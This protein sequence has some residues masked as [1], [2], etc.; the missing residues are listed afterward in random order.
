MEVY[1]RLV[2][3]GSLH[4]WM[5]KDFNDRCD[6]TGSVMVLFQVK[7][8]DCIG[9]YTS[10][11]EKKVIHG[12]KNDDKAVLFNVTTSTAFP[13]KKE[14]SGWAV[15]CNKLNGRPDYG[16]SELDANNEPFN[17]ER[18][19]RSWINKSGGSTY[20]VKVD[21]NGKNL[22]TGQMS[23]DYGKYYDCKFTIS[24]LEVWE[25]KIKPKNK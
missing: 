11:K 22:L 19:C 18:A 5:R 1:V 6:M 9:G 14:E 21:S 4:G 10:Q 8:G 13:I 25:V 23:E 16:I 12:Y 2:Y 17:K 7:D 20:S 24:E 15:Y 3:R